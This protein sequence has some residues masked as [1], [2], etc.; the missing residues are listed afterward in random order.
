LEYSPKILVSQLIDL[1]F[2]DV[3]ESASTV[4]DQSQCAI[5]GIA[6]KYVPE[7]L[8]NAVAE[9]P[10][11]PL[12]SSPPKDGWEYVDIVKQEAASVEEQ[13]SSSQGTFTVMVVAEAT[14]VARNLNYRVVVGNVSEPLYWATW[15]YKV[16]W[17]P[18]VKG[19]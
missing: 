3:I 16:M 9:K 7:E 1:L 8:R 4:T 15:V 5:G 18:E 6:T 13:I 14:M 19:K 10:I 11:V 17:K 12:G 2:N